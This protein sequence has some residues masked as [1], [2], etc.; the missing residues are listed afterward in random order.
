MGHIQDSPYEYVAYLQHS[1]LK[2]HACDDY[3]WYAAIIIQKHW[4]G[5]S[6]RRH[7]KRLV[8]ARK[9]SASSWGDLT[10]RLAGTDQ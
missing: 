8:R 6:V 9:H 10:S 4:R 5:Y 3:K 7:F 2:L 1:N